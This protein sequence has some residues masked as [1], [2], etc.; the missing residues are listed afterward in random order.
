[1]STGILAAELVGANP[2]PAAHLALLG[3]VV[4]IALVIF[5]LMRWRQRREA[6]EAERQSAR[7]DPPHGGGHSTKEKASTRR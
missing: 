5:G 4:V 7:D 2:G 1:M 6:A 3:V